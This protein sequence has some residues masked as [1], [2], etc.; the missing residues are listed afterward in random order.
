MQPMR[1]TAK[2]TAAALGLAL[3]G[4]VLM[5]PTIARAADDDVPIDTKILRGI[6]EASA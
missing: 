2:F 1:P 5:A 6:L 4:A 3:G